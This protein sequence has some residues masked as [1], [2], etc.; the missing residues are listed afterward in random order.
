MKTNENKNGKK[1][2]GMRQRSFFTLIMA[3]AIIAVAS[4]SAHEEGHEAPS[5]LPPVG[6]H[7]GEFTKLTHHYGEVVLQ[8]NQATVYILERDI[9]YVAEDASNVGLS[10]QVPGGGKKTV[11]LTKQG[12]G[13]SGTVDLPAGTRRVNFFIECSLDGKREK[14]TLVYELKR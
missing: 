7:G 10:Y 2:Q 13:Y 8:G 3:G 1:Q 12:E 4:L 14:G 11:T 6:P 5:Q 9:K